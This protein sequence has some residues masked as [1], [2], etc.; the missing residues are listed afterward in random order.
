MEHQGKHRCPE[1]GMK[2]REL[3]GKAAS[4][5]LM[6]SQV[7]SRPHTLKWLGV[8]VTVAGFLFFIFV[9]RPE[10]SEISLNLQRPGAG[11]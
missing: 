7:P 11:S 9:L 6:A 2:E 8:G 5:T 3:E 4:W 10:E 1:S